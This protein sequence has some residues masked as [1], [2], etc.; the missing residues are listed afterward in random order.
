MPQFHTLAIKEIIKETSSAVSIL[1]EIPND[2]KKTYSFTAG[3]YVTISTKVNG[4][5]LR[6]AYSICSSEKSGDLRIAIKAIEN[7]LFSNYAYTTL[8]T[9]DTIEVA[10]PEGN[11]L[12]K[13]DSTQLK[14]YLGFAAGSGITPLLSM[15]KTVLED[16]PKSTFTLIYGNK[17]AESTIFKNELDGLAKKFI[18]RFNIK[19]AFTQEKK[20]GTIS[21]RINKEATHYIVRTKFN[22]LNFDK[23]FLCGPEEMIDIVSTTLREDGFHKEDINYEL[24]VSSADTKDISSADGISE[25]T[26]LVDD[27]ETTFTMDQKDTILAASLRHNIDAPYSCQGGVCS[28]C[29]C[30][31]T[32]GHAI[33]SSNSILT[34][35]EIEEGLVLAC[36]AHPTTLKIAVDFDDV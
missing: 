28:S 25:I 2:L 20:E 30:K 26:V 14:N 7:G 21:G 34:D 15:I 10:P 36:Q 32:E 3:Q 11:F 24:F 31:V 1:F 13:T 29:M 16:E 5:E 35:S 27:E 17:S 23:V 12:L 33:M 18:A 19:Y 22:H 9:G 4:E 6:R 8:K